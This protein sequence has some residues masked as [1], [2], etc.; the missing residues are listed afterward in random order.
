M[1]ARSSHQERLTVMVKP[2]LPSVD[3]WGRTASGQRDYPLGQTELI[4]DRRIRGKSGS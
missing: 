2:N 1:M 3:R 4:A